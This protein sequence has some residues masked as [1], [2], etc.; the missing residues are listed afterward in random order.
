ML[1]AWAD[2][3]EVPDL[4]G[5]TAGIGGSTPARVHNR[6][7]FVTGLVVLDTDAYD[8]MEHHGDRRPS[9]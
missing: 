2:S 1:I 5:S 7:Q 4:E 8:R 6:V 3:T 9:S